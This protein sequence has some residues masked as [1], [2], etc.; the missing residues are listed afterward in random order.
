MPDLTISPPLVQSRDSFQPEMAV[1]PSSTSS[2]SNYKT[3]SNSLD[4]EDHEELDL[5]ETHVKE[6]VPLKKKKLSAENHI[7]EA[8]SLL[9]MIETMIEKNPAK[10]LIRFMQDETE[11][12]KWL[13]CF[14]MSQRQITMK[15]EQVKPILLLVDNTI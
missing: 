4:F 13:S 12:S 15:R 6:F 7:A 1:Q 14:L 9:T 10:E 2:N 11:K 5:R 3:N 8:V